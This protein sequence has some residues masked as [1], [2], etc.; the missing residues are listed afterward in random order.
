[1]KKIVF[2][3][4]LMTLLISSPF[5]SKSFG[6]IE[7]WKNR[8]WQPLASGEGIEYYYK[9]DECD[10]AKTGDKIEEIIIKVTNTTNK[11]LQI[12]WDLEKWY[13]ETCFGCKESDTD[14]H[15]TITL[16]AGESVNGSCET[17]VSRKDLVI[18]S[19]YLNR[20]NPTV[21]TKC[22]IKNITVKSL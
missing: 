3:T 21:F 14:N 10:D 18:F 2:F 7:S 6:Q 1:M 4:A 19:M 16:K 9:Y 8:N 11:N 5:L 22:N 12:S 17:R 15:F 20:E 13:N